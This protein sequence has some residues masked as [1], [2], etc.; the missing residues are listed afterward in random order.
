MLRTLRNASVAHFVFHT[1]TILLASIILSELAHAQDR[2][3][4]IH[5]YPLVM[6]VQYLFHVT[7]SLADVVL[8]LLD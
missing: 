3:F 1:Y 8:D 6:R 5:V 7:T 2:S 4:Y